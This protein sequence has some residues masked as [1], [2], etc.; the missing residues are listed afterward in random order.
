[1]AHNKAQGTVYEQVE[2]VDIT[3]DGAGVGRHEQLVLFVNGTVPGDVVD[4][5]VFRAKSSYREC[6]A[7]LFHKKSSH[8]VVPQCE[9]FGECGGCLR[10]HIDYEMQLRLKI[11]VV[12][13]A[14][15]RIAKI[16]LPAFEP[17][18]AADKTYFYRN[19]L[20]F[21]FSPSRWLTK[22]EIA[23][24]EDFKGQSALGFHAPGKFDKV[25]AINQCHLQEDP[26]NAIRTFVNQ[27]CTEHQMPY[28][29]VRRHIGNMRSLIVRSTN[30]NEWMIILVIHTADDKVFQL[31]DAIKDNF[32]MLTSIFY[33]ENQKKNDTIHDLDIQLHHGKSYITE[34]IDGLRFRIGPKSFFQTNSDQTAKLY[35]KALEFADLHGDEIVYDLYTGTGTIACYVARSC[36]MVIGVEYVEDAV[37]DAWINAADNNIA[38]VHFT[39]GDMKNIINQQFLETHGK[40][41]VIITDPPR[42]GMHESVV[43]V[44]LQSDAK[45]IVY[46]SCNP[47]T[48][49]RDVGILS[50]KYELVKIQPV[51]MFPHTNH[52]ENIVLLMKR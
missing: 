7:I 16:N 12:K 22:S 38:N 43:Q 49:A 6:E 45:K 42:A 36:K 33:V 9:H 15:E 28:Y 50:E 3:T 20:D 39:A 10:Q 47:S 8:R 21:S 37:K 26:S 24:G 2:I 46:V 30:Q 32:K 14:F 4:A 34:E 40:P 29:D 11:K 5:K 18:I 1:M 48:Q 31:L 13:D 51:D 19:K 41:D 23:S 25:I 27:F 44:L 35:K 52:V 17:I